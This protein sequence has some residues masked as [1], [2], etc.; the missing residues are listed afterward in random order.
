LTFTS[1]FPNAQ[2]PLHGL[3]V[4]E[5]IQA[6]AQYCD[7]QVVAPVPWAPP[8]RWLGERYYRYSQVPAAEWHDGLDVRHPRF[9]VIPKMLKLSDGLLM[10]ACCLAQMRRLWRTFPFDLIDAHWAYP[11]GVA[12]ALL[13]QCLR[14]PLVLTVRGDDINVMP[15][16]FWH[17]QFI[18]WAL[19]HADRV[20]AL[21]AEL[22]QGVV[23]LGVPPTRITVI[24]N[25]VDV[26]R[27]H[28]VERRAARV[29]LGLPPHDRIVLAVGRLHLSK[30][31]PLLVE[32]VARLQGQFPDLGVVIVGAADPEANARPVIEAVAARYG[33]GHRVHLVGSQPPATLVDWYGAADV[34]CLPTSREGSANVL[35]E[36]VACGLPCV[37]TPV[38]GNPDVI[39]SPEVGLLVPPQASAISEAIAHCLSRAWDRHRIAAHTQGRT[40]TVVA[41][42]CYQQLLTAPPVGQSG[43]S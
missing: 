27:F 37:T 25:G 7:V 24:P 41:A 32:A 30:G 9:V 13:A 26:Q 1:L 12:A 29:R 19:R 8:W 38:G 17:R 31:Y 3:F 5:R 16:Q 42:E 36:A 23:A 6:L 22:Q 2:Q 18:R 28:P 34:F 14:L 20:I 10:A 11:D 40:W 21:S 33:V 35:L 4:R 39:S 43:T 15:Q